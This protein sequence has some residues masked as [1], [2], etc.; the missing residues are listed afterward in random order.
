MMQTLSSKQFNEATNEDKVNIEEEKI[1]IFI[2]QMIYY[3]D[4][5]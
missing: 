1:V 3:L 4:T 2:I 5:L